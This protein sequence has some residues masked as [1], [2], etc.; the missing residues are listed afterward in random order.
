MDKEQM[1]SFEDQSAWRSWLIQ[2]HNNTA[3]A[4]LIFYKKRSG[5]KGIS[6]EG[7]VDEALCFGWIDGKLQRI[8]DEKHRIRFTMRKPGSVWSKINKDKALRLMASG[9]M[10]EAGLL[11]IEEAKKNG[12]WN[13]AYTNI[14]TEKIPQDLRVAL[15]PDK[16]AWRNFRNF[17]N[18][19]R[20]NYIGWVL[21]AKSDA[22]RNRRIT[23]VVKRALMNKKPG[24]P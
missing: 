13:N 1:F 8:D 11:K 16:D 5:K 12:A 7:A 3:E 19:Y 21:G 9:K 15:Q 10:T 18:S 6:Y 22:T 2:N 24:E 4:W 23:E 17:A 14:V 20:N